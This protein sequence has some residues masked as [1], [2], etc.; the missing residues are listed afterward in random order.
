MKTCRRRPTT[1]IWTKQSPSFTV[2]GGNQGIIHAF[3]CTKSLC[4]RAELKQTA[5]GAQSQH[6]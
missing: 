2:D 5:L 3:Y 6:S 4:T 1:I